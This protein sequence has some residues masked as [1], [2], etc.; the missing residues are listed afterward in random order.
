MPSKKKVTKPEDVKAS[1]V[2]DEKQAEE[3]QN[4]IDPAAAVPVEAKD[5]AI[6]CKYAGDPKD[7]N[8][9]EC[10]GFT[11][12]GTVSSDT[13][14]CTAYAEGPAPEDWAEFYAQQ[15]EIEDTP[16]DDGSMG[17]NS[18]V[19][20]ILMASDVEGITV[21]IQAEIAVTEQIKNSAGD[22]VWIKANFSEVRRIPE[23]ANY[24]EE[25][26]AL[27]ADVENEVMAEIDH[28]KEQ[29]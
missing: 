27:W 21:N 7:E 28:L 4:E 18:E 12:V 26:A 29:Y 2:V 25:R 1:T 16:A 9:A 13:G 19:R 22:D 14:K 5:D 6:Q 10:D 15:D 20:D 11:P 23:G 17:S 24:E 3:I 8:C